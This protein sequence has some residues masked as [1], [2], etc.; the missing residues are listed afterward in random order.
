MSFHALTF[1]DTESEKYHKT[2]YHYLLQ[3]IFGETISID[4]CRIMATFAPNK[5]A[6]IFLLQ[7]Q[8]EEE[9][10]L[11]MLT[12][13]VEKHPRPQVPVSSY[14]KKIDEIMSDAIKRRD[15][16]DCVLIQNFI[17]EGLNISL[18][19]ELE[20]HTDGVLSELST[21]ILRDEITHMEFGVQE[22]KRIFSEN[23]SP[24]LIKKCIRLQRRI[25]F[26]STGLA[27]TL[28]REA[29]YLGIPMNEFASNVLSDHYTRISRANF[30]LPFIDRILFSGMILFLRYYVSFQK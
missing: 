27:M 15:Y 10:H 29:K 18:L 12:D 5:K 3:I 7:Q 14:L 1:P 30:P 6:S 13:Y 24:F 11:E 25:L 23:A 20:H 8:A 4:Y 17:V 16:T 9:D 28:A 19:K 21:K 22:M 2:K 26:Y